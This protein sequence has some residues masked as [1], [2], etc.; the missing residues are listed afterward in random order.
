LLAALSSVGIQASLPAWI[1]TLLAK[2]TRLAH[3]TN[4]FGSVDSRPRSW[5]N[6]SFILSAGFGRLSRQSRMRKK[7]VAGLVLVAI[8]VPRVVVRPIGR[9]GLSRP[10]YKDS[11]YPGAKSEGNLRSQTVRPVTGPEGRYKL[12]A[13][14]GPFVGL[15]SAHPDHEESPGALYR[16][17]PDGAA[18][19][20]RF[21][22]A[23]DPEVLA[24]A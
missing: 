6:L 11:L 7:R 1:L 19:E 9:V 22:D 4:T 16:S 23:G 21:R 17:G 13:R 24:R 5:A 20:T 10:E 18:T 3:M 12:V 8:A 14:E 2:V 15:D